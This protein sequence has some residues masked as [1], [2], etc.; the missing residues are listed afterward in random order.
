[1]EKEKKLHYRVFFLTKLN[2]IIIRQPHQHWLFLSFFIYIF[3]FFFCQIIAMTFFFFRIIEI[4]LSAFKRPVFIS[5][6]ILRER[7]ESWF[8]WFL[9]KN[10]KLMFENYYSSSFCLNLLALRNSKTFQFSPSLYLDNSQDI[11]NLFVIIN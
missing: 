4:I 2:V 8:T 3:S 11:K 7:A 10:L 1:V 5:Y 6:I 9:K